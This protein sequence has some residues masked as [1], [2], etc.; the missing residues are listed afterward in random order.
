MIILKTSS[1]RPEATTIDAA[2]SVMRE[3]GVIAYLT[4]TLYGLGGDAR[5]LRGIEKI[6]T[7]KGRGAEKALP[8]IIGEAS[9]LEQWVEK[10]P[11]LAKILMKRFWPG[12]LTLLFN[13]SAIVP[14]T[15]IG[16]TGKIAIRLPGARLA[17]DI[18][19]KLG[20][21]IIATSAN[22]SGEPVAESAQQIAAIFGETV[23][24]IL[25]SGQPRNRQPSTLLDVTVQPPKLVR[26]GAI[27]KTDIINQIGELDP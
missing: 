9:M 27:A 4:D 17:R 22:R 26:A 18:S 20:A 5:S 15:L 11:P 16:H 19:N 6:F 3:G 8:V 23:S 25:D 7:I 24:L 14:A 13:A 1:E 12:P 21:P 2:V 10:I